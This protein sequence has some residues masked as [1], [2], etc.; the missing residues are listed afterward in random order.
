MAVAFN[1]KHN[2]LMCR[3]T[4]AVVS[5]NKSSTTTTQGHDGLTDHEGELL[6]SFGGEPGSPVAHGKH[7][8]AV[9]AVTWMQPLTSPP[10]RFFHHAPPPHSAR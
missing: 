3:E 7:G 5:G 4:A 6:A 2:V 10:S 9:V 1:L 8:R